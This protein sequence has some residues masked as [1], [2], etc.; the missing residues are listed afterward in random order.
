MSPVPALNRHNKQEIV[1]TGVIAFRDPY[2]QT[3]RDYD[4]C[5]SPASDN[6][7]KRQFRESES[8]SAKSCPRLNAAVP[9]R[10]WLRAIRR[11][12]LPR[13]IRSSIPESPVIRDIRATTS[14]LSSKHR[15]RP[16]EKWSLMQKD[17]KSL[18][19]Q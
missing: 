5:L 19:R 18:F 13:A 10:S 14:F 6:F 11:F 7:R 1:P 2:N 4:S 12:C 3:L 16:L 15:A 17:R 8:A 9:T